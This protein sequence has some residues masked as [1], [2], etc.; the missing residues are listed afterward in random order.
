MSRNGKIPPLASLVLG[1][2]FCGTATLAAGSS[3]RAY[4]QLETPR[5]RETPALTA[6]E[7][8]KIKEQLIGA[9]DRQNSQLRAKDAV[10][11]KGSKKP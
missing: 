1:L 7:Q 4:A 2:T 11:S 3:M 10:T 6:D 9:R 5:P 8:K